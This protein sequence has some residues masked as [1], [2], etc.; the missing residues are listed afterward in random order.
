MPRSVDETTGPKIAAYLSERPT[1]RDIAA[2]AQWSY[3]YI[4]RVLRGREVPSKRFLGACERLGIPVA[5]LVERTDE[6]A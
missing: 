5:E 6:A 3:Q 2:E 4:W 1:T